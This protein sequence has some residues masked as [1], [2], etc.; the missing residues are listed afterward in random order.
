M[1]LL[2]GLVVSGL[3]WQGGTEI[4]VGGGE[5]GPWRQ[6][7]SRYHYVDDPAVA[8]DERGGVAVAWVDQARK[9]VFFQRNGQAINV[10]R[11]PGTFSWLPRL[12]TSPQRPGMF[13]LLWQEIVFSGGSHGGDILHARSTDGG[14]TFSAPLNLSNSVGGDGKGRTSREHWHNGSLDIAA[15]ADGAVYAAWTEYEGRLL[16]AVS[17]DG[18]EAFSE[19]RHIAGDDAQPARAPSLAVGPDRTLYLAWTTGDIRIARSTDGGA[20]FGEALVVR[21]SSAYADAPKIALDPRNTLH[22]SF[23]EGGSVVYTRSADAARS[24]EARRTIAAG[25]FPS[26][27]VDA[28]GG[29]YLLWALERGLGL[30]LSRSNGNEFSVT[31]PVPRSAGDAANGNLQGKLTDKLAVSAAGEVAVVNSSFREGG[32]SRVWLLRAKRAGRFSPGPG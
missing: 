13:H 29:V 5:R 3:V 9:D 4:A 19:P 2:A 10:S 7:E 12:I 22:L 6:N 23:S 18:G 16:L 20:T 15:G 11:S 30:A 8:I 21:R 1:D 28:R 27:D 26:L 32:Q 17:S 14:Q 31:S 24:F 25:T